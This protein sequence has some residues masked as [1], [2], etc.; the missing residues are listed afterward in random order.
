MV[1]KVLSNEPDCRWCPTPDCG[2]AVIATGCAACPLLQCRKCNTEFCY[3]CKVSLEEG[4]VYRLRGAGR[5]VEG[6]RAM[7]NKQYHSKL[8]CVHD[9]NMC[10]DILQYKLVRQ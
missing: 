2:Y 10:H 4:G 1:R 3:H 6:G 9:V 7:Y 5:R 8:F